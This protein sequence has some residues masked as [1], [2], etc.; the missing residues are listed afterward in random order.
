MGDLSED[1]SEVEVTARNIMGQTE[2]NKQHLQN[3]TVLSQE[4]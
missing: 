4:F 1:L 2:K 3:K